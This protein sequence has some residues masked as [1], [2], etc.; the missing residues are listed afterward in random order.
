MRVRIRS[1]ASS[2]R[3]ICC[4]RRE[5]RWSAACLDP[6][7]ISSHVRADRAFVPWHLVAAYGR[8]AQ[9]VFW[10]VLACGSLLT[11][12][13]MIAALRGRA[14]IAGWARHRVAGV[15]HPRRTG[16]WARAHELH[17][18]RSRRTRHGAFMLGLHGRTPLVT[19]PETSVL[20][21]GPT[22]SGKTSSLVV[23]HL[24]A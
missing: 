16:D 4:A 5:P 23:P 20:V 6:A 15:R 9:A 22:R 1:S 24:F 2:S 12:A 21:V 7:T 13:G 3:A 11:I 19:Q 18:L 8:I 10:L 17:G 14:A